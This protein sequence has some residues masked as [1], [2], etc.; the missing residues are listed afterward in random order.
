MRKWTIMLTA[1]TAAAVVLSGCSN[2]GGNTSSSGT[3]GN[4]TTTND[5]GGTAS[6]NAATGN[7]TGGASNGEVVT[8]RTSISDGEL[9]KDQIAEFEK[10]HS[11]IKIELENLDGTKLAAELATGGAP[12]VIRLSGVF[13]LPNYVIKGIALDLTD[14]MNTSTVIKQDDLLPITNVFRFD[15]KTVGTGPIYGLPKDWSND[16][17][18]FYNKKLFDAAG[19]P[20]PDPTKPLSWPEVMDLAK[21]LTIKDGGK[22]KQYGLA[23][24][25]WGKTEPNFNNLLQ[26][27]LSAGV[28]VSAEDNASVDFNKPEVKDYINMWVDAVK[29]NVG[30]NSVNNDQT[31]GGDLFFKDQ[32]AMII[33]GYWYSGVIRSNE[34]AKTH[35][36]DYGMLP[37]P[38]ALNGTRVVPTGGAT[39]A[40]INK[41]SKH[42]DEAWTFFE[43]FFSGKP[44]DDRAKTGWGL[45]IFKS[46]MEL[47]P[48][49]T[50]FDKQVNA[51]LQDELNYTSQYL[52]VNPY[53]AGG[54]WSIFDK[55]VQP[56]Y[57]GK[58][59]IDEAVSGMTKDANVAIQ[60]AKDAI[61]SQ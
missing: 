2:N 29:N 51:V 22:I 38:T 21:K 20:L 59:N 42:P 61:D 4:A 33:D 25:E 24:N 1:V 46:K 27:L 17:A 15:G 19:V 31:S 9:S 35:L 43:W 53:L 34:S 7:D 41:A 49:D 12:D 55:Y 13:D 56:L 37:T 26:Y 44:A 28:D 52:K 58:S 18:I 8:I 3:N 16:Y 45:P 39:G 50:D 47:L 32:V 54:G 57:F 30:P 14:R 60:E 11:N 6:G 48:K 23:A 5:S 10:E 36:A 40:I